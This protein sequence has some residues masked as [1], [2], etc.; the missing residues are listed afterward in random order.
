M[1]TL[2]HRLL[3]AQ[4]ATPTRWMIVT[5][6]IYGAG[7]N[8]LSVARRFVDDRPGWGA[9]LVDLRLHGES[10][11]FAPPH[12]VDAC[13]AD[14]AQLVST[15][16]LEVRAVLGH[17]FGGKVALVYS[18][19]PPV[20]L[21]HVWV[22]DSTPDPRPPGGSAWTMLSVLR[23]RPGPFRDRNEGVEAV[24]A[25]G[26]ATP[27]AQW[28]STNL[29]HGPDGYRWRLAPDDMESLLLSFFRT[30]AWDAVE[31]PHPGCQV[32]M[33]RAEESSILNE[34][35]C[36]RVE[37]AGERHGQT[38]LHPVAGGHWVN[39]DNPD[40]LHRLLLGSMT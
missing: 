34:A 4:D 16:G 20:P 21:D 22:I 28:M 40:A 13:A 35:A 39:A 24:E 33:V 3:T 5:H 14:L 31:A 12:T 37:M 32:H 18:R 7:R 15:S 2:A 25:G 6:G 19:R 29:V 38:F 30:D 17:S 36:S 26:F 9:V 1:T 11:G 8:W 23:D 27:V 10:Q